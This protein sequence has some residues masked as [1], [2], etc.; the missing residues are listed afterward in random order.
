VRAEAARADRAAAVREA[1]RS[2]RRAGAIDDATLAAIEATVPDDR[3]RVGPV[4]AVLLF[5]FT[6]LAIAGAFGFSLLLIGDELES[7]GIW[8]GAWGILLVFLTELQIGL[9]RRAHGGTEAAT[10]FAALGF[11]MIFLVWLF[12]RQSWPDT[13]ELQSMLLAGAV[14]WAV[15]AWRWGFPLYAGTATAALLLSLAHLPGGRL[16]WIALP[17]VAAPVLLRLEVSPRLP[18]S[19][20]AG[21][22]VSLV[23]SL[24]ALYSAVH[25]GSVDARLLEEFVE[26]SHRWPAYPGMVPHWLAVAATTLVP[27][28]LLA[29]GLW[30]RHRPLLLLGLATA[31]VS[32]G[33]LYGYARFTPLWAFL[34][35]CGLLAIAAALLLRSYLDTAPDKE[36][37]GF[38]A[39][40][41]FENLEREHLLEAGVAVVTLT[42]DARAPQEA[43]FEGK[44]GEFGGG[45][46]SG[47]W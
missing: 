42:P 25:V 34:V 16:Y 3:V 40:P 7:Y 35:L 44:G 33:T 41:L 1:A 11:L 23:V 13:I 38:T 30:K 9:F 24:A 21:A 47:A 29:A 5:V 31:V 15:A 27:V 32:L 18:P 8:A 36:R 4:F 20:R 26:W 28:A 14:L 45:G 46:S 39:E 37:G 17:L 22:T 43:G 2:W 12:D 19:L 10:S 6:L